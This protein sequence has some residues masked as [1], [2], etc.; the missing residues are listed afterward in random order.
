VGEQVPGSSRKES[1]Y[2]KNYVE[3]KN[4]FEGFLWRNIFDYSFLHSFLEFTIKKRGLAIW[5]GETKGKE[6][7]GMFKR[8]SHWSSEILNYWFICFIPI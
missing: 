7:V 3:E 1:E 5:G 4:Y 6:G 8:C 2:H